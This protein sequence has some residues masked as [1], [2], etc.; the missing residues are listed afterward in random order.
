[1]SSAKEPKLCPDCPLLPF[2]PIILAERVSY[3]REK[4]KLSSHKICLLLRAFAKERHV[5]ARGCPISPKQRQWRVICMPHRKCKGKFWPPVR[6]MIWLEAQQL[7]QE[8][9]ARTM[10][11]DFKGITATRRE[12]REGG[13]FYQA[14]LIVLRNLWRQKKG[15]PTIEE[16]EAE[17]V[18]LRV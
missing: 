10:G 18:F 7:Y 8:E 1:M 3:T 9:Q 2:L 5:T 17:P 6:R 11:N 12:L 14:K 13:Y 4:E 16:E 15:L